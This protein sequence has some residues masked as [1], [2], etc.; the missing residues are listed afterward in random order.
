M[1]M[2]MSIRCFFVCVCVCVRVCLCVYVCVCARALARERACLCVVV[3]VQDNVPSPF[4]SVHSCTANQLTYC[5]NKIAVSLGT[6][7]QYPHSRD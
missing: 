7:I 6:S 2:K 3:G 1:V 4:P 5:R